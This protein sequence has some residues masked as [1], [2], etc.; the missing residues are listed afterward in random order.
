MNFFK[1]FLF[2]F[3]FISINSFSQEVAKDPKEPH[4]KDLFKISEVV[5]KDSTAASELMKRAI[6]WVKDDSPRFTKTNGITTG[7][8]A[9]CVCVFKIKPKELNPVCD[10]TGTITIHVSIECK[11]NRYRYTVGKIK[12]T[13]TN[14][15]NSGGDINLL[16]PECGSMTMPANEWKKIK[17]EGKRGSEM[18]VSELLE[19]MDKRSTT[20]AN[21]DDW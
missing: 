5:L 13:A 18:I 10:F 11:E 7:T 4:H 2:S 8:K 3:L 9:E 17:G 6:N 16:V 21:K 19:G 1:T 14:S 15:K 12:H 20:G